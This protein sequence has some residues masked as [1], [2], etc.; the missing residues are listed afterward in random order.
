[1]R[2]VCHALVK[3]E[4]EWQYDVKE[5]KLKCRTKVD[6]EKLVDDDRFIEDFIRQHFLKF[7]VYINKIA[8]NGQNAAPAKPP[9]KRGPPAAKDLTSSGSIK[10]GTS[11]S[12]KSG[13]TGEHH[14]L[15]LYMQ[16]GTMPVFLE[17]ADRFFSI[18]QQEINGQAS[19]MNEE[20]MET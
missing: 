16:K 13:S 1:M 8:K 6:D 3:V 15:N 4:I 11:P 2:L 19:S 9:K 20:M 18:I 12:M 14:I 7:Y 10:S 17:L 5:M